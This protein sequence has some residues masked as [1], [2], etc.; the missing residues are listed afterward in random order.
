VHLYTSERG[1]EE[2][3]EGD[4]VMEEEEE[5]VGHRKS[6][7]EES[8][9][10]DPGSKKGFPK[11]EYGSSS[12]GSN[13]ILKFL[14]SLAGSKDSKAGELGNSKFSMSCVVEVGVML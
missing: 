2:G 1:G 3:S 11:S 4:M 5:S 13:C 14:E 10:E 8:F 6:D 12:K 9:E 7:G